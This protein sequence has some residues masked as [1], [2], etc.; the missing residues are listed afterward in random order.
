MN[1]NKLC[2]YD[3]TDELKKMTRQE[4]C[5]VFKGPDGLALFNKTNGS[6]I[7]SY[8]YFWITQLYFCLG[9]DMYPIKKAAKKYCI[10]KMKQYYHDVLKGYYDGKT[11]QG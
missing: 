11:N 3:V 6:F 8:K 2:I 1:E 9:K 4:D 10:Q 5:V 7:F